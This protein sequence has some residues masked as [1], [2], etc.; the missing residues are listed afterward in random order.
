M[1]G[2]VAGILSSTITHSRPNSVFKKPMFG[3]Q[4]Q[5]INKKAKPEPGFENTQNLY[6]KA[7]NFK[8][9]S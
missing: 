4:N 8:Q 1:N 5:S 9:Y 3:Q 6:Q 2:T 7:N